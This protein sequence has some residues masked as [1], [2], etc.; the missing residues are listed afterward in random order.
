[1]SQPGPLRAGDF[2]PDERDP[3]EDVS[4]P[5]GGIKELLSPMD[6]PYHPEGGCYPTLER[7]RGSS[8]YS[9]MKVEQVKMV[10]G[11]IV[12]P[13]ISAPTGSELD[14]SHF[15]IYLYHM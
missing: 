10:L 15:Q 3:C 2:S 4:D 9:S 6:R 11:K 7:Q 1:M 5:L 13:I 12:N 8:E 14:Y